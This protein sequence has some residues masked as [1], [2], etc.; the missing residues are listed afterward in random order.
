MAEGRVQR[1]RDERQV[2]RKAARQLTVSTSSPP[3]SGPMRAVADEAAAQMPIARDRVASSRKVAVMIASDP[4]TSSA[5]AAPW[6]SRATTSSSSVGA[7]PH[8]TD[9]MPKPHSPMANTRR[10]P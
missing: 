3:T 5:P 2:D 4:G 8:R 6:S 7:R 9:V 10:R 1:E